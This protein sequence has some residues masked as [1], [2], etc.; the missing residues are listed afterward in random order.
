VSSTPIS[1]A[2]LDLNRYTQG[3]DQYVNF[4]E[5][6]HG[7]ELADTQER[8]ARAVT[9]HRRV[10]VMS[11]N[12]VGKSF[13]A[14][15]IKHGFVETN[16]DSTAI[17]T[18][19]SYSQ[20]EDAVWRTLKTLHKEAKR[21][22]GLPGECY[23]GGQ[24]SLEIDDDWFAKIVSP[25][26]PGDLEGRHAADVF[27]LIEEADKAYITAEHF[28]S[29]GSSVTDGNDRMLAVCNPPRDETNVVADI[30]ESD[31]WHVI[32]FSSFESHNVLVDAGELDADP[33]PG[34]VDLPTIAEDWEDW[35]GE[36]WP[37]APE[38][39]R[40]EGEYPRVANL[41]D[42]VEAGDT[43]REA[44]V[45]TLRPGFDEAREAHLRRDDLNERWY[46][47][48]A[49]VIPPSAADENR[50]I[51][52]EDV[53]AAY[54]D[55]HRFTP[56]GPRC[57]TGIDVARSSDRT[58]QIDERDGQL[59]VV[60]SE[61]GTDHSIQFETIW[62]NLDE[63]PEAPISIDAIGEGSGKADDTAARYPNVDR[64]KSGAEA[65][66]DEDYKNRW[67][68][69]VCELG[70]WLAAGGTFSDTRLR[71]E[72]Q[73]AARVLTLE[74]RYYSNRED[75]VFV[76]DPKSKVEDRLG[77]SPDHLDAAMQAVLAAQD[78]VPDDDDGDAFLITY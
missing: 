11:G 23:D 19:G 70:N 34:L 55:P 25:R 48:R 41:N 3:E 18:S 10:L 33:I 36:P 7:L 17:G 69:G 12:G 37:G 27:V 52:L 24:P 8:V 47:R 46:R 58:V 61:P 76:S 56:T 28:D 50:P 5:D 49:G 67:T 73:I 44:V 74:E 60:Y 53:E 38:H 63:E 78:V 43:E 62:D 9:Q 71:R 30:L 2:D 13:I 31:R 20:F 32:Q 75:E 1:P 16:L 77:H 59:E 15:L 6:I 29:A 22:F 54:V 39:W 45:E 57:G 65:V 66:Q 51:E 21:R 42:R 40:G 64:F 68:E 35:N 72:L 26:D 4:A 14:A